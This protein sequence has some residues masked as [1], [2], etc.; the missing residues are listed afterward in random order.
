ML[1]PPTHDAATMTTDR[2]PD[3]PPRSVTNGLVTFAGLATAVAGLAVMAWRGVDPVWATGIAMALVAL[4]MAAADLAVLKVHRRPTTGLKTP[5][6][7]LNP[8]DLGRVAVKLLGLAG[9]LA[10]IAVFYWAMPIY[11]GDFYLPFFDLVSWTLPVFLVL[12]VPYVIWAD[13]RMRDPHDGTWQ[14]GQLCLGRWRGRDVVALRTF[15]LGWVIKAFFLPLMVGGFENGIGWLMSHPVGGGFESLFGAVTWFFKLALFADLAFVSIGYVVTLRLL[16]THIRSVNPLVI[17]WLVALVCYQPFWSV[18]AEDY[19]SYGDGFGWWDWLKDDGIAVYLWAALMIGANVLWVWANMTFGLRFS[20]LT[21]R[22]ILTNG[23]Y[24]WTKHPSYIAK[25]I[26]WWLLGVPFISAA[27][28]E[29]A[30]RNCLL[31]LAV[32][33]I[34]FARARTEERHLSE[35]PTYVAYAEWIERRGVFRWLGR[36]VPALAYK[37]PAAVQT[38]SR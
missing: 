36:L 9:V 2:M 7:A 5:E 34:Y 26:Y 33:A 15:L 12:T 13:R 29:E 38:A 35:D 23:P 28:P 27:G 11:R 25:N 1:L 3:Q 21:H 17:G 37:A 10:A 16:D 24:R 4:P 31:L 14:A 22:G 20:N 6:E 32:N 19:L 8:L 18:I 30:L